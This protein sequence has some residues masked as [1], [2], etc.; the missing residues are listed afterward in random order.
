MRVSIIRRARCRRQRMRFTLAGE[1]IITEHNAMSIKRT[2]SHCRFILNISL[3]DHD[4]KVKRTGNENE[5]DG[6]GET[7]REIK[8]EERGGSEKEHGHYHRP[9]HRRT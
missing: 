7:D 2:P 8:T 5:E 3:R 6:E 4:E 1:R 9:R